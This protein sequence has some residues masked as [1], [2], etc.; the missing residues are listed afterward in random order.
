MILYLP[1]F[2]FFLVLLCIAL[3][4][5]LYYYPTQRIRPQNIEQIKVITPTDGCTDYHNDCLHPCIR[6]MSD[7]RFVMVQSPWYMYNDGV[8]NPILYI[9]SNPLKWEH[10]IEV[11]ST[12][13]KGFN[14][15]PNVYEENGRIY[16]FWRE[17]GTE[18]CKEM[19]AFRITVGCYT[20]DFG[21]T[22]STK[23]V[24]LQSKKPDIDE[25][26]CPILIKY[27]GKYRFYASW[28]EL[29]HRNRHNIGIAIWEGTSLETPDFHLVNCVDFKTKYVADKYKQLSVFGHLFFI[30][31]AHKF[32]LWHFDLFEYQNRLYMIASEEMGDVVCLLKS[33]DYEHFDLIRKPLVNAHFMENYVGYRQ[34]YYKPTGYIDN[35]KLHLYYTTNSRLQSAA[36][37]LIHAII[38]L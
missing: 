30:P 26:L 16:V 9:S 32:D 24:Y 23:K 18:L 5:F 22:F 28:Y 19:N 6:R 4:G 17:V 12:P 29:N 38:K 31:Q 15:D 3:Y 13:T 35:D 34:R 14:S 33:E 2:I 27:N 8:E 10:G 36:N 21:K 1:I 25:E 37:C 11:C 7:G 20:D